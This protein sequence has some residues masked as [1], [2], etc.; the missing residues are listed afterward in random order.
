MAHVDPTKERIGAF[1]DLPQDEPIPM[2][3]LVGRKRAVPTQECDDL[4]RPSSPLG[5]KQRIEK[6]GGAL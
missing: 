2:L 6:F 3:N 1:K 5:G 4:E